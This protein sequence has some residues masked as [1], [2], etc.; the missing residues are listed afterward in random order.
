MQSKFIGSGL[1]SSTER[2]G[3]AGYGADSWTAFASVFALLLGYSRI[4]TAALEGHFQTLRAI[5]SQGSF[6][7]FRCW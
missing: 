5:A 3:L 6:R 2:A 4:R 7:M 1:W